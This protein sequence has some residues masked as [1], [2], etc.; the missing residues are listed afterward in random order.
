[1]KLI[2]FQKAPNFGDAL[3]PFIFSKY[4]SGFF[5][6]DETEILLGIGSILHLE[7]PEETKKTVFST[8]YA[9]YGNLPVIDKNYHFS[10]VRG[11]LTAQ[12]LKINPK[13]AI[14]DG[15]ALLRDFNFPEVEK[16]FEYS[17]IPHH[18]SLF[19][20]DWERIC[21]EA[22]YHYIDPLSNYEEILSQILA[23]K[24]VIAEAMHGAIVADTLRVPWIP[25]KLYP[26]INEFKWRDWTASMSIKYEPHIL[27]SIYSSKM[28]DQKVAAKF[29]MSED[30]FYVKSISNIYKSYQNYFL[31][32]DVLRRFSDLKN[33]K[34]FLSKEQLLDSKVEQLLEKIEGIKKTHQTLYKY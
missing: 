26:T 32:K 19:F 16:K 28:I 7:F 1:M 6:E 34:T 22:G 12:A 13:L 2:Y 21:M 30:V 18:A 14:T 24:T 27:P 11:P 8:G 20:N 33:K 5:D 10:C 25:V 9:F 31:N 29:R 23:S 17:F 4:F 15:A 3:N